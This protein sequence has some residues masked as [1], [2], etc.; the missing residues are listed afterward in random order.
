[1]WGALTPRLHRVILNKIGAAP[2]DQCAVTSVTPGQKITTLITG[3]AKS[4]T[5][6]VLFTTVLDILNLFC[7]PQRPDQ[8]WCGVRHRARHAR[9]DG[10]ASQGT[11]TKIVS[12]AAS[13]F[14]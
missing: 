8:R 4:I 12:G 10:A 5:D 14:E 9:T 3:G 13:V 2:L 7:I 1:V 6:Q 11:G